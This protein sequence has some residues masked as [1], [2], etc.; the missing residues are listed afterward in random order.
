MYPLD[1]KNYG[2]CRYFMDIHCRQFDFENSVQRSRTVILSSSIQ[3][4]VG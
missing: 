1:C 3:V 4:Q 2:M